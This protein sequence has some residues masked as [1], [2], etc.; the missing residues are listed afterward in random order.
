MSRGD[1]YAS[2]FG[3]AYSAYMQRPRLAGLISRLVW[4]G[5]PTPY[6]ESMAAIAAVPPGGT[7]V[8]CPCGAGAALRG[9][10]AEADLRYLA[11]DLS[12]SMLS[13]FR[14]RAGKRGLRQV[15][16]IRA[17]AATLPLPD[18][19][20]DLFLS[21]WGL[22]C[23]SDPPAALAEAA[24]V[25]RPGGRLVGSAFVRGNG[26]LR[27]RLLVRPDLGDFGNPGT[28]DE[29]SEWLASSGF[30]EQTIRRSGPMLFFDAQPA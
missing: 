23:F 5:D 11:L 4:G 26:S 12:P 20:A 27:Q 1:F 3:V 9:L 18:D 6:Y 19:S 22:H 8:D 21:Y 28:A 2:P 25:L 30:R 29:V 24:R 15:E 16:A 14:R 7:V 17:D 10:A 13:R